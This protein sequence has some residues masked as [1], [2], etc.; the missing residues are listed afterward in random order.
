[1]EYINGNPLNQKHKNEKNEKNLNTLYKCQ[2]IIHY[3]Q[4]FGQE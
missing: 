2:N 4:E 1:M 3:L